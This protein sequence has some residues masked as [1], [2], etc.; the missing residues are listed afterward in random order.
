MLEPSAWVKSRKDINQ[1]SPDD[2][3]LGQE[4]LDHPPLASSLSYKLS[5]K[6]S[7]DGQPA[8]AD[9]MKTNILAFFGVMLNFLPA[10]SS[11]VQE[12]CSAIHPALVS[13]VESPILNTTLKTRATQLVEMVEKCSRVRPGLK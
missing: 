12:I 3:A 7:E 5:Q 10:E 6:H 2:K 1:D 13:F 11:D 4:R 9:E 8:L